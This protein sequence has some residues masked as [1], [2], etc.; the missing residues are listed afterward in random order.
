MAKCSRTLGALKRV[1]ARPVGR[2]SRS[3]SSCHPQL[4]GRKRS[5]KVL[6]LSLSFINLTT[7]ANSGHVGLN[8]SDTHTQRS[9]LGHMGGS[10][11][12]RS[13]QGPA[14]A[15]GKPKWVCLCRRRPLPT[16]RLTRS[17]QP[18]QAA[19]RVVFFLLGSN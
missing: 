9:L 16:R 3:T 7:C 4:P 11:W 6:G 1:S 10:S 17:S 5:A 15:A 8:Q 19:V 2:E 13:V 12:T 14:A 18:S